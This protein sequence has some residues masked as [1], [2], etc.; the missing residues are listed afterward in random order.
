MYFI[1]KSAQQKYFELLAIMLKNTNLKKMFIVLNIFSFENSVLDYNLILLL[2]VKIIGF[3]LS[4]M[5]DVCLSGLL[6][7]NMDQQFSY[8]PPY[9]Y[10]LSNLQPSF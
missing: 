1:T 3:K 7:T 6:N 8:L 5:N 4:F 2:L 10:S 9:W